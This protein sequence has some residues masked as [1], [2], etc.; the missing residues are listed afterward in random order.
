MSFRAFFDRRQL[1][2]AKQKMPPGPAGQ[3]LFDGISCRSVRCTVGSF[4]V[5]W[6]VL[7]RSL[8]LVVCFTLAIGFT[9]G[10]SYLL[11]SSSLTADVSDV[12]LRKILGNE[13]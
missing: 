6:I 7:E 11:G 1:D 9:P 13:T 4:R 5:R 10:G 2:S 12:T 8:C 3:P